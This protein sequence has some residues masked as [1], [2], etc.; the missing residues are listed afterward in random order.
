MTS[1]ISSLE[2]I[3]VAIP[4]PKRVLW[5][6][7]SVADA[8]AV[9]PNGIKTLLASVFSTFFI[10]GKSVFGNGLRNLPKNSPDGPILCN[11]V[12]DNFILADELFAKDLRSLETRA[13][14]N[15]NLCG[16]LVSP[17]ESATTFNERFKVTFVPLFAGIPGITDIPEIEEPVF[18]ILI[19]WVANQTILHLKCCIMSFCINIILKQNKFT[20]LLRFRL[21][22]I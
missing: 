7:A 1:S 18:L 14:V 20:T 22:K 17:F 5:I 6:S 4:D 9:N 2:I 3:Y 16:K 11:W 10:K 19:N 13:L 15:N 21:K 12:F 8:A